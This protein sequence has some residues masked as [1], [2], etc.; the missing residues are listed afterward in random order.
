M[1]TAGG[2]QDPHMALPALIAPS[3][4]GLRQCGGSRAGAGAVWTIIAASCRAVAATHHA[5]AAPCGAADEQ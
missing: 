5:T 3:F 1:A 4:A 2:A